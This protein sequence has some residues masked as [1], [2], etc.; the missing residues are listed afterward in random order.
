MQPILDLSVH[1]LSYMQL[2]LRLLKTFEN[3]GAR[4]AV[5]VE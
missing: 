3:Y 5:F 1:A 2:K 4:N